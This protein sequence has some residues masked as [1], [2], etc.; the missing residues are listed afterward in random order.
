[1]HHIKISSSHSTLTRMN[2]YLSEEYLRIFIEK[3]ETIYIWSSFSLS[4]AIFQIVKEKLLLCS[5]QASIGAKLSELLLWAYISELLN[6]SLK[7]TYRFPKWDFLSFFFLSK[8]LYFF[9]SSSCL[10]LFYP[11]YPL[12]LCHSNIIS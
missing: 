1:M 2:C 12:Q 4:L 6:V 5:L 8:K 9:S 3:Y 11:Y 10:L 7:F